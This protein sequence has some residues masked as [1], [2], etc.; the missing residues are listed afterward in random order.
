MFA[1]KNPFAVSSANRT[2]DGTREHVE[3][4]P[5]YPTFTKEERRYIYKGIIE[6]EATL[7]DKPTPPIEANPNEAPFDEI[8][9]D[10]P[11]RGNFTEVEVLTAKRPELWFWVERLLKTNISPNPVRTDQTSPTG[12][13]PPPEQPPNLPYFVART[14]SKLLPVYK[15]VQGENYQFPDKQPKIK[16]GPEVFTQIQRIDGDLRQLER[17]LR[18]W[19]E[20]KHSKR[21]LSAVN[22]YKGTLKLAGD[23]VFDVVRWLEEQGF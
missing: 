7:R 23:F 5:P 16:R 19:L 6:E 15:V 18:G 14:R 3:K 10:G 12:Y 4:L 8:Y 1:L 11:N 22:E 2:E 9:A 17:D 21:I 13:V 20:Q